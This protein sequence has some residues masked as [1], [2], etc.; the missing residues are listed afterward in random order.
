[1][2]KF[3]VV[4]DTH[5]D[6]T[7]IIKYCNRPYANTEEMNKDLVK[8]WNSVVSNNDVVWVLGDFAFGKDSAREFC[9]KLNGTKYLVRGNHDHGTNSFYRECGFKEVYDR[10]VLVDFCL[11]S[12]APLQLSETTPYFNFYGHV[13]NDEKYHDTA[14][15]KCVSVERINY[16][17]YCFKMQE[18]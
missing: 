17:P 6:H 2:R 14:T 3:F 9:K 5:F 12:H 13:H 18:V 16:T 10:P 15:S 7:N 1:M 4:S 8:R 11:M